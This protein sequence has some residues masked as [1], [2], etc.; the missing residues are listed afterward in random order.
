MAVGCVSRTSLQILA[1]LLKDT[2]LIGDLQQAE[3]EAGA[4][5]YSTS[6]H[7]FSLNSSPVCSSRVCDVHFFLIYL[8]IY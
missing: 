1:P 8:F 6:L 4:S 5:G 3:D 7:C 2:A